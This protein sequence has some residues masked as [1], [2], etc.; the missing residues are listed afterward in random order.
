[1]T[2]A[3]STPGTRPSTNSLVGMVLIIA[4]VIAAL[5]FIDSALEK[6]EQTD[7]ETQAHRTHVDGIRLVQQGEI[8]QGIESLRK[9]HVLERSNTLYELDLIDA[10][11]AAKKTTEAEPLMSEI[12]LREPDDGHANLSA[13]R[14]MLQNGKTAD[15]IS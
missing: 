10:L 9:S 8:E 14:L 13:A 1:M 7:L 2:S 4:F 11:I 15:A 12:L 5:A 6:A 3:N